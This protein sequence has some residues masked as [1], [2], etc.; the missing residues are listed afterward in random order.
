MLQ[1]PSLSG[2]FVTMTCQALE[3]FGEAHGVKFKKVTQ[4][5]LEGDGTV[6]RKVDRY[7][8]YPFQSSYLNYQI[9]GPPTPTLKRRVTCRLARRGRTI[10]GYSF[11]RDG[12]RC[13]L[14]GWADSGR[15]HSG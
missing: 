7:I 10:R 5:A 14:D 8:P 9:Q 13:T 15:A 3:R 12:R 1:L 2:K 6:A 4:I 11:P